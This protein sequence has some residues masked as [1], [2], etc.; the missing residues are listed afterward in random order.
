MSLRW[1]NAHHSA[2]LSRHVAYEDGFG[3]CAV[4]LRVGRHWFINRHRAPYRG[5]V[6]VKTLAEGKA[7]AEA[8]A[9]GREG[10][11]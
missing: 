6:R 5:P 1:V 9:R 7:L 8:D 2:E 4:V 11:R 3:Y 10:K